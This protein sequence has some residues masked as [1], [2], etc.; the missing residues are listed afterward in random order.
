VLVLTIN[1]PTLM[2]CA[3]YRE[4]QNLPCKEPNCI[5]APET[6]LLGRWAAGREEDLGEIAVQLAVREEV[7]PFQHG[8]KSQGHDDHSKLPGGQ[9]CTILVC[10]AGCATHFVVLLL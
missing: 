6:E 3:A 10:A 9:V 2:S 7:V 4:Q 8:A 1:Q 5:H